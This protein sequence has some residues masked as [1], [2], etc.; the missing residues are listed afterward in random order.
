MTELKYCLPNFV[1][2]SLKQGLI[3]L[4]EKY[5]FSN[6]EDMLIGIETRSSCP[7]TLVRN[8]NFESSIKGIFPCGEG[9]G[10]AGG[11]V[12]SAVDGIKLAEKIYA[13]TSSGSCC[14]TSF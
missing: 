10:Y 6:D 4:N 9:A 3:K 7:L 14:E 1:Y 2:E 13:G 11:I 12:S 5:N 8:E